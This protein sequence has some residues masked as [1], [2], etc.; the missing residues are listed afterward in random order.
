MITES[1]SVEISLTLNR[2]FPLIISSNF[3]SAESVISKLKGISLPDPVLRVARHIPVCKA[4]SK[5]PLQD[6]IAIISKPIT[7][8]LKKY[9]MVECTRL[10]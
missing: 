10:F 8:K 5:V 9:L 4:P 7:V 1:D 3:W 2:S 6:D